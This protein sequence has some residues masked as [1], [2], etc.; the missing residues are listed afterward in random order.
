[1][2]PSP[3]I[4]T[5][6]EANIITG[7]SFGAN[8]GNAPDAVERAIAAVA[9]LPRTHVPQDWFINSAAIY[10]TS[11]PPFDLLAGCQAIEQAIGR[12]PTQPKGPRVIDIDIIFYGEIRLEKSDLT[13]PHRHYKERGFV[14]QPLLEI[15]PD[16]CIGGEKISHT[17]AHLGPDTLQVQLIPNSQPI[18][19]LED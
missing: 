3:E 8:L 12:L 13:I 9:A 17:L 6:D 4:K 15:A 14:L 19:D 1:M 2:N 7:L 5:V 18:Q 16:L 10:V 11:L